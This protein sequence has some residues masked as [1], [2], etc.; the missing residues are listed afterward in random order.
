MISGGIVFHVLDIQHGT[1]VRRLSGANKLWSAAGLDE[2]PSFSTEKHQFR[3]YQRYKGTQTV[4]SPVK[5][6]KTA[7]GYIIFLNDLTR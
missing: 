7:T 3:E 6:V 1:N 5:P 2:H 4:G